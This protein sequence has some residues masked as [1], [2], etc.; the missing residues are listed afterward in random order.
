ME[1]YFG[2]KQERFSFR[3][4]SVG[5]VSA[6]ISS[7]FF[8]SVLA[9][10]SVDAQ[11]TAG[12]HYKYVADSELSSEE[13]KQLVYD[14]PTYVENDDE[15]YYLVYKLNSQNQLAELPNTGSKN[16]RQALVAGASLAAL[17][18]LIFAV[19]KKK[20]K[21]K[22]VLHLVLVAGI[23]NGVLVSVH[24]LENHLLLNY[25]TDYELTSGEKLPLPKEIS[26]YTYIGYIK[27][28]KTTSESEVSNQKSSVATSTK[29]QKVDY[30]VT[31]NFVDHPSTVQAIQEQTPVSS[32]KPTEVQVVEKPFST[33]LI[34]PRK[35]EKQ[36]SD[37]QE[38]LAEH[39]N[40]ETKKEE[41]ISPKEKTGVNTLNP[42]DE[43]LSGQ[44]NK[45]ELL[46]REETIETKIDFQEEIQEN[47]DLA[48]GTVRVKQE[49]KL[50]KKVEIVRIFSVNKE[51]VSREIVS[52]STTAPIPR[53]VEKG[54]KK[55][56]VIKEQ[57][58][59]GVEHKDVQSGA[60]V[61]PAIQ[62][63]LPEAVVSDK[64]VPEVQ[65]ALS[66]AVI[67]DKGET[68]VQPESP[69]TVVSDKGE[70]KQVA[71]LPE[72]TGPQASAI[73]EP[74]QVAPL[75]EYTRPQAGAVVEPAIQ[76]ELP[77]AVV[78]DKGEPAVQPELPEAVVTDKG[79]PEVQPALPEAVVTEKGEPEVHEKPDYT[80]P[81][82]ANLVE[83]EVHEKLA[84]TEPVGTTGVDEN[85]NLI[86][87]PVN[88]IP[89]YTE[90]IS[91]VSEVASEREELPSLHT[92][93]RTETIPKTTIEESD[94]SKFIGD[95]SVKQV[96][97]DGERQIVTSY[98]E[99]HGKK[100]S[101][102]VETVTI[103]KEMKPEIIVK[104]TKERPKEK[105]APVLTL[106]KVT[107][108]AMNRSANL[109]YELD[110]KDNA[111]IS[112]IV[113][114]IKDGDTVV[115]RVDLSK[116]KL[117]DAVQNLDLFKDYK[118]ATTMIY[119]RGQGSETSKLDERPLRLELKKVEIKNIASTNLVKVNDDGTETPSDFMNEK[120][121]EE[122]V[123]KMYLKITSRDNKVTRLTVDSIEEVTEEGQKLYKITAEAQDLI[124]HT[125]PTKVRNKYVYYIEKP[126][127][128]EDNVYY[129]FKDL[130]DAMNT[131]KNGTFKLGADLNATGVPTPKKWYV[132]GDFRGTLKSVEGK[133]YTIHNTERP[134]FQNIIGGTVTKV[135]LGNVNI[136]MPWADRIAPIADT[137]KGGAKIEDVKVTGNVLGR[138]W[139]SGFIDKIDNQGTLRNVAFIGNVTSVGDGGQ[140]LTGIVG[141]NWKGLVERAY[142]DANLI[143]KKAKAAGIAYWTQNSGDNH[144]VGVE[145]AVKKGIVK[146]TIQVESPVEVGGAVGRLSHHGYIGEVVSMMKV[147]KGEIFYGSSDMN[148]DPYW[149]AN[150][151]RGNYVV[152][153][154]SEGTISYA[155][156]K[157]HH[158]IKPISQ[159]EADTKIMM[160]GITAQDFAVNE[161]VVNRLN[162]L[163]RKEDE[164][165]ST[166]D[167]KV[168]RDLAYRNIEKLQPFYNKEWIVNQGNKLAEDSNLAKKEVL[169]VTGMKDGQ[170]VTDL[171]DID[172]IM[173]HYADGTKEEMDVTKN[174]DS[175][176]KQVREYTIAGQNVVYTPN[177]VEKDR[178]QLIQDIKDKLAS[179]QLISPE[180]RA[181]MDARKKPEENTDERKNGYIKDLYLEESFAETK[182]NLDKLVKS[183]VENADHQLNSDEAAMKALVKKVDENKAKIMMALT[184]LNRY[185]DIKYG[186][187]TIKN[188]MMFK[189][190]FYGKSVDLLDF[191]IRIGS[192]ERN[193]KG[194]R[195]LDAYR[196]MIGGTIGKSELHGFLD[197][198]MRLFTNDTDLND[199]FIHAA[200]N[201]YVS[202]PQTTNPDFVNKRH[203]AFDGLNNGVHNRM[204]L[205]L[206]TLKNAHMFL[207]STYNTMAYSSFEKYGKYTEEARNEFKKEIDKVAHAQQTYLDFWSR[208]ALPSVRDQLLKSENRVPTPVWDN[209]NY[210]GIKGINRMG[211]DEKKVP[212][213]P[214]RELYGPTW[215]FHNTN[216]NM[217]AMASIFPNPN[218]NDQVYFMGTNMISPFG[219]SAFTHETTHVNDRMLYFGGHRHRQGTDVEAYAQG[220]LQT[221]SSIGHQGEYGALGLNMAYHR[222]NDGDQWY[223]Y[224]PDKLQTREDI[225][226]YMKNYNEALM[227]LDHVEADAVLPQLN[228]DNSKWFKKIDREM[229]RNLGDGLNN[230]VAP[231]QWDNVRDLNQEESSKK[232]SSIN[233]LIDNNFMTK[234]GNPGNGRYRP[235][236]FRP[237][238]AYV[239]VN[240][241]AGIYGGN[242]SQ[243]APGSLSFK[244][245]A[246]RMWGYYGYDKGFTSY[247]S[248][249]YQGE[250]DKQN[251]GR[252]GDDFII[253]KVSNN[254][255]SNLEDWKK[256][257][258]H[259]VKSRAEKGFTEITIDGQTIHNYNELKDLF[260]K[261]VTEDL[262]KAGNYS[263]TENL[264]SKVFKALLKNT[265]GFFNPLFKKDI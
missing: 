183:L 167:Y 128:K 244:H 9:S 142:V 209:Q 6:T 55:T 79:E 72:Y 83:S 199:W 4:L 227:M 35:E 8:M 171:S 146:G 51:E 245:N 233:D 232:L 25:N 44:L 102:S 236:D 257:W 126:H 238:S 20:V 234:H 88:D 222:E 202:E 123:K 89:E 10:S 41:K 56:Q 106:T 57:P 119:D 215:K 174:A 249:K 248:S 206:L 67:T 140:F 94:P 12:V 38:Q 59:T 161:P 31:P 87:P 64:G 264:K 258:Y 61:E 80:Q 223:N 213:A 65:P 117:T 120:P 220:M 45:P 33:E 115:K 113:A 144:K 224:D 53:I 58:E 7:L 63:E 18:I 84:Y 60:I 186:D 230:L 54:T 261:A 240:M 242:T 99:L 260:D 24:A 86:E 3:K 27:E 135:N 217:G 32:T 192:S 198:N 159:S 225:D 181:L 252:L 95:N 2:E 243:G 127:P 69:D 105:T 85:G 15:T 197:Y 200:K 136:N 150:N 39:K 77:E 187:M 207:I 196:D 145:G 180:V 103:L 188:L 100:I 251:Q 47:P 241:M 116:E 226:R 178:N 133:H 112:S 195:T 21:N 169:S 74:E 237:N 170:F 5:L 125:D 185:Y 182:A 164:Y 231:H 147:K 239:N 262:K 134:L 154:V 98:E 210:S 212:I 122:D 175:K 158:R 19:S 229:R 42:Q 36:S 131:D 214:I 190:D 157:E 151:V 204:I 246:F 66:K 148:D 13:K 96:G 156:A 70:P 124:Q 153:G 82:G 162:R 228:G 168:D 11:E 52:T 111:E 130:V 253:K 216:W 104:G 110:N 40:L 163:T 46:Y 218:N 91:T 73:V 155:R 256:Y 173:V 23:G 172:K 121:S 189:P 1:K 201:V 149:V 76:P 177:M 194:D 247:V 205:P 109:N 14:I 203:R 29:Q 250:A 37:S 259:D 211:Y 30:N 132:D 28:G 152:N 71:P 34:N 97:E 137:I 81:I 263:N 138:N 48:E 219:I 141:E 221:P 143:G 62:P 165:K 78:T 254:Q 108:D 92:D 191:L 208:L 235:E 255:F 43:V 50:G 193:I 179:V 22:T 176:V 101:E 160:L 265:D 184:Y 75:P 93:I 26:G 17:G 90:P 118:I 68:E 16:E 129:N 114:E 166:Q 107:E 139:V 49:G